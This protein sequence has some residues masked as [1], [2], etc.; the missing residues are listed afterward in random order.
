MSKDTSV[1]T[2]IRPAGAFDE[3]IER[4]ESKIDTAISDV[5]ELARIARSCFETLQRVPVIEEDVK[6][7]KVRAA[8]AELATRKL[9]ERV[10]ELERIVRDTE[11]APAPISEAGE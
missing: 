4:L 10:A 1:E 6:D 8:A 11:R 7:L 3:P 5:R 2:G 9:A